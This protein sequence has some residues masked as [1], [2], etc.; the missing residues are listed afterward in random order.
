MMELSRG[1]L[2]SQGVNMPNHGTRWHHVTDLWCDVLGWTPPHIRG[3]PGQN[4][5]AESRAEKSHK[6]TIKGHLVYH[7]PSSEGAAE[8]SQV[9][10]MWFQR[11]HLG[12]NLEITDIGAKYKTRKGRFLL[13]SGHS[14]MIQDL[15]S[16]WGHLEPPLICC[17][18]NALQCGYKDGLNQMRY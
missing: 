15:A 17:W 14:P 5:E 6:S 2:F 11:S 13:T 9:V 7:L 1:H 12:M 3:I 16:S 4:E 8:L 18:E 10:P